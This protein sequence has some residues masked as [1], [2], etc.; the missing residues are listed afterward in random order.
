VAIAG[1]LA[2]RREVL[3]D[4][5]KEAGSSGLGVVVD[6]PAEPA[7]QSAL[8]AMGFKPPERYGEFVV[9]EHRL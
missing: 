6:S 8:D 2:S 1:N 7:L 9:V 5:V 4:L 3:E